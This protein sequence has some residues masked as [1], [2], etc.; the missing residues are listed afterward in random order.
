MPTVVA[1]ALLAFLLYWSDFLSPLL[2]LRSQGGY[3]L[4]VGL[5]QLQALDQTNWPLLMAGS[6]LLTAPAVLVFAV[7][8]RWFLRTHVL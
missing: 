4:P 6:V 7:V 8:Q 3:T 1:V 2:Y 5:R